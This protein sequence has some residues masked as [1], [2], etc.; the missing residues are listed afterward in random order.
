MSEPP[1]LETLARRYL[2]LWQD[3]VSALATDPEFTETVGRLLQVS[4]ALGPA[5]WMSLWA[6]ASA[7]LQPQ[8]KR[9]APNGQ[10]ATATSPQTAGPAPAAAAPGDSGDD[11]AE[12]RR[13]L[14]V[15]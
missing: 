15:L 4:A 2:D 7:G 14:A 5:G 11:V 1:T 10:P 12:L 3:Q 6:A 8:G 9:E 13:R